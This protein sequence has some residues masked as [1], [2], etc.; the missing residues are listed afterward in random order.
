[1]QNSGE[2]RREKVK[3]TPPPRHCEEQ[4]DEEQSR[5][6][7]LKQSGLLRFARYDGVRCWKIES[8]VST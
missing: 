3:R 7:P 5:L 2:M 4:R 6:L 1:M 8:V